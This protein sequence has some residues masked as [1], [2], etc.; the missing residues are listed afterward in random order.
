MKK[1]NFNRDWYFATGGGSSLEALMG[2][3]KAPELVTLPHDA[4]VCFPRNPE[5]P[6]GAGNGYFHAQSVNYTKTFSVDPA[7]AEK[8]FY[9]EFEGVYE[10][11]FV[12]VNN[13]F[14]G[15]HPYG[16]GN[17]YLDITKLVV[18]GNNAVKVIVKNGVPSGRWYTGGGIYRDVNLMIAERAHIMPDG[19]QLATT[20]LEE[21]LAK[22][23]VQTELAYRGIG[24]REVT[25]TVQLIDAEGKVAAEDTMPI[26]LT[27]G[28]KG[29]YRQWLVVE[30]PKTWDAEH[31][32]LY[33]YKALLK[34]GEN[35]LDS[36][37]G[38]FGIR[39]IQLDVKH[40]LRING[41]TVKL[42]GGCL[43]H[44]CGVTGTAEFAH[45]EEVRV[46][47]LKKA[48]FNAIRSSHYPMSRR[49]IEECDR[50]GMYIM[51]EFADVWTTTKVD[52]DYGAFMS[53]WWEYDTENLVRKD[54]NHPSVILYSIGNE[55]PENGNKYDVQWGKKLS[56]KLRE[57]DDSRFTVN[58]INLML[59]VMDRM[60]QIMGRIA[61]EKGVDL[62]AA[63]DSGEINSLM[64]SLGDFMTLLSLSEE[65]VSGTAEAAGQVDV[66]GY[67]YSAASYEPDHERFPNRIMMGSETNPGELDVNWELVEKHP[68]V[69]GDFDWTCYDY[70]GEAGIGKITHGDGEGGLSFY[71]PYPAKSAYCGD[72]DLLGD[73]RP[74]AYWRATIW[75][76]RT[77]PYIAV[78]P[79]QY[80]GMKVN[81]T[82]WR[83]SDV[84]RSWTF[85]GQ[86]GKPVLIEVYAPA[87]EIELFI[88]GKSVGK[89]PVGVTKKNVAYFET[90]YESGCIEAVAY[91]DGKESG[92]DLL[93]TA[94]DQLVLHAAADIA[95]IPAD[96]SDIGYVEICLTDKEGTLNPESAPAVTISIEGPGVVLGYGSADPD[97]EENYFDTTA[98]PFHGRLRAAIRG[99][100]E[101]GAIKVTLTADG[102]ESVSAVIESV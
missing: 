97:S 40:G 60:P 5:E 93:K 9:L 62:S 34:E 20:E 87:D 83:M 17:F 77:D 29:T 68:Y 38:S 70:L 6:N 92:R 81:K 27:E 49:L 36:E 101:P 13:S 52:Y 57:L 8:I 23:R 39:K 46:R 71:A 15:K 90:V 3:G 80:H 22:V 86:D 79:P 85:T 50:Q 72:I 43:H 35:I 66:T 94:G 102:L 98:K 75:G 33:T 67:N 84:E 89:Q 48:G 10:N 69:I 65:A 26:T 44:D 58:S 21:D 37:E 28:D 88:N 91:K 76:V 12:Y 30:D 51:D 1:S 19:V 99:T 24:T 95:N 78:Q 7:D 42:A 100:G 31:P 64:S 4:E 63:Q 54:Y 82:Q 74:V 16:Y 73:L 55:I 11:A 59:A 25:L 56:D 32:Y 47:N 14:A 45:A 41:K 96:G 2:G 18:P 53:E 61:A